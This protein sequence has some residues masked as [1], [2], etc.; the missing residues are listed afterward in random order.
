M[1]KKENIRL[2][3]AKKFQGRTINTSQIVKASQIPLI[4]VDTLIWWQH[5]GRIE[6]M[7][8]GRAGS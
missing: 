6:G 7:G 2:N 3:V 5:T 8:V 4:I 1:D